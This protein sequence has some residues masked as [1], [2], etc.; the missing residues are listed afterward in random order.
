[1][2]SRQS[3]YCAPDFKGAVRDYL[4]HLAAGGRS[5]ATIESYESALRALGT[6]LKGKVR[7]STISAHRLDA[8]VAALSGP[9]APGSCERSR[10]TLNRYRSTFRAF[11][12]WAFET[13][14][15]RSNPAAGLRLANAES[16]PTPPIRPEETR[17]FPAAIRASSDSL[18]LRDQALFALYALTGLRRA[19]ALGLDIP[20]YDADDR[21]IRVRNGKG[22]RPRNAP[23]VAALGAVLNEFMRGLPGREGKLFPGRAPGG[24]LTPRQANRRFQLW[25]VAAHLREELTIHSFRSG[26]ATAVHNAGND[27]T[28]VSRALGHHDLRSTLRYVAPDRGKLTKAIEAALTGVLRGLTR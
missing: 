6:A 19:E 8:A 22:R 27:L 4:T 21:S 1:M 11:F 3:N 14:R 25:K 24:G 20:D 12:R 7:L 15:L 23:V 2:R 10:A 18:R 28:L 26:F 13:G 17:R 16:A 9:A 5:P